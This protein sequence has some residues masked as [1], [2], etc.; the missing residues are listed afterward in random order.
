M[1]AG[2]DAGVLAVPVTPCTEWEGHRD[3]NGYGRVYWEGGQVYVHRLAFK[4][5][6]GYWPENTRHKCDNPPCF[7]PEHL[8]DGT[9]ADN[10]RDMVERGR[11][12]GT[13]GKRQ[14]FCRKFGHPRE[15]KRCAECHR[16]E[17][18]ER[19]NRKVGKL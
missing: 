4:L 18:R 19:Y 3:P 17:E 5:H 14:K 7:N 11:H 6:Y 12:V 13:L 8:E 1:G 15:G 16:M 2:T 10:M 9:H